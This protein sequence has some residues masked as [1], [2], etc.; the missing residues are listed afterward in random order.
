MGDGLRGANGYPPRMNDSRP[1]PGVP[2]VP[3]VPPTNA[4]PTP[5]SRWAYTYLITPPQPR[6]SLAS[7]RK[8]LA[9]E[10]A[11]AQRRN[12]TWAARLVAAPMVTGI[13]VVSDSPSRTLPI[14]RRLEAALSKIPAGFATSAPVPLEPFDPFDPDA[15]SSADIVPPATGL[16]PQE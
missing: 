3:P 12:A 14:N 6:E 4:P 9:R 11:A 13:V 7:I 10:H 1:P 5:P 15:A 2:P 8:M 16:P